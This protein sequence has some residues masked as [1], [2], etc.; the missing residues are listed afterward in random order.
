MPS[1]ELTHVLSDIE[2]AQR[3]TLTP[4]EEVASK[5]GLTPE[6]L[7]CHGRYKAKIQFEAIEAQQAFRKKR[8]WP[9]EMVSSRGSR[10]KE[11]LGFASE[12]GSQS[13]GVSAF[14]RDKDGTIRNVANDVF[15]PGDLFCGAWHLFD[16][17]EGGPGKWSPKFRY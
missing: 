8:G 2:I 15:G 3:A 17:L 1:S 12:D 7:E 9:F 14:R 16:L 10:F 4:I 5:L 6:D 11:D 13:P